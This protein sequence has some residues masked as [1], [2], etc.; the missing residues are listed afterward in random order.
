MR[1]EISY[2]FK[3]RERG[4]FGGIVDLLKVSTLPLNPLVLS[5]CAYTQQLK[6]V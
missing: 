2:E 5:Q 1:K 3:V 4:M 6:G